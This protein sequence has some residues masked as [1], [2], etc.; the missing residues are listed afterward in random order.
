MFLLR[1][2][3]MGRKGERNM[4]QELFEELYHRY[5]RTLFLYAYSLTHVKEDAE[6]LTANTFVK[7]LTTFRS[8][9]V[10]AWMYTVL[11]NEFL[12]LRK[13]QKREILWDDETMENLPAEDDILESL[14]EN[15][16]RQWLY[17]QIGCLPQHEREVML[18]TIQTDYRDEEIAEILG[19]TVSHIRVLRHR[20][21][22]H[23]MANS[24]EVKP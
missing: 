1:H 9:N 3:Y 6:D 18:L 24:E 15:Q 21:K 19:L 7:A 5:Y 4:K 20:A 13:K 14:I 22:Q 2:R 12:D 10:Q 16:Q 17:R 23:I 8:G 11:R